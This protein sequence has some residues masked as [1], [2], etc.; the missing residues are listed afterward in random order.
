MKNIR[1]LNSALALAATLALSPLV[2][3]ESVVISDAGTTTSTAAAVTSIGTISEFSPD[4]IVIRSETSPE[5][6][7]YSYSKT[8]TYVDETG[9]PVSL[10]LV[11]SGLPVT[12]HYTREGDRLIANRVIVRRHATTGAAVETRVTERPVA[13]VIEESKTTTTTT[14]DKK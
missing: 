13:P 7:R 10:E 5:P 6:L 1:I 11:K 2:F 12:V 8:T 3:A 14:T 9:A 4:T